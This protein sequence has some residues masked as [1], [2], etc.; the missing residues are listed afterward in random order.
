MTGQGMVQSTPTLNQGRS[1]VQPPQ[2]NQARCR[3]RRHNRQPTQTMERRVGLGSQ[4]LRLLTQR[5][6][7]SIQRG[8]RAQQPQS[9]RASLHVGRYPLR[10]TQTMDGRVELGRKTP[11]QLSQRGNWVH[12]RGRIAD[13]PAF[14][15]CFLHPKED[16]LPQRLRPDT[17]VM[18]KHTPYC[19]NYSDKPRS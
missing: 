4:P 13:L 16:P 10:P 9:N 11:R 19:C 14:R 2:S 8:S 15:R 1:G 6:T 18:D 12:V 17:R 5:G 3:I 7:V